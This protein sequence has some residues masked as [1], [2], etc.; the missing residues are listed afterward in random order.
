MT[1]EQLKEQLSRT[2]VEAIA[3]RGGFIIGRGEID[4]GVDLSVQ[5]V[6]HYMVGKRKYFNIYLEGKQQIKKPPPIQ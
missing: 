1:E 3:R 6:E 4:I 2:F 5:K